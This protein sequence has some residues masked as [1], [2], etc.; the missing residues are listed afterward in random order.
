MNADS[1]IIFTLPKTR[2]R[3][4][5]SAVQAAEKRAE[6]AEADAEGLRATLAVQAG[7]IRHYRLWQLLEIPVL[8]AVGALLGKV[9]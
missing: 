6:L 9:F 7:R 3:P 2:A 8:L 1:P 4:N 5:W